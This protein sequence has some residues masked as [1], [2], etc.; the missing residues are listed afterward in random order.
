MDQSSQ[1][2]SSQ[3]SVFRHYQKI[4]EKCSYSSSPC[5]I[6]RRKCTASFVLKQG[7]HYMKNNHM[8]GCRHVSGTLVTSLDELNHY[9]EGTLNTI[10]LLLENADHPV[11]INMCNWRNRITFH[12]L[13]FPCLPHRLEPVILTTQKLVPMS[14]RVYT[15]VQLVWKT[16]KLNPKRKWELKEISA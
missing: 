4:M 3:Q 9:G 10:K 15:L 1:V 14:D 12:C 6:M 2:Q 11:R 8:P 16:H 13:S 7:I 5:S